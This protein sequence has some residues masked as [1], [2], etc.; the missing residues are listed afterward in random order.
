MKRRSILLTVPAAAVSVAGF[1]AAHAAVPMTTH[2][3][4]AGR[5]GNERVYDP[6]TLT[7]VPNGG[8]LIAPDGTNVCAEDPGNVVG[9]DGTYLCFTGVVAGPG[10]TGAG[11]P[12]FQEPPVSGT[13]PGVNVDTGVPVERSSPVGELTLAGA[14]LAAATGAGWTVVRRR[15][16]S[17]S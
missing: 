5:T 17:G 1:T 6:S 3:A 16:A 9:P 14:A 10:G 15:T 8:G 4:G 12:E 11:T 2:D 7:P 13:N